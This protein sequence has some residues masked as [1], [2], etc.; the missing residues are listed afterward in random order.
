MSDNSSETIGHFSGCNCP[1]C[2]GGNG[3]IDPVEG[4]YQDGFYGGQDG[5]PSTYGTTEQMVTQL[6]SGY[7]QNVGWDAHQWGTS[8]VTY[9]VSSAYT[10]S[11]KASFAMAFSLWSEVADISFQLVASG[12]QISIVE[13]N[14]GSAWSGNTSY[15][16]STMNM[17]S[18]TISIDTD[19]AGWDDIVTIGKYG[20]QTIL[21]EIGHSLGLG[22][23]GNYNGNVNY[24][25]QVQYLNDNRQYS[26][27]SYNNANLLG[28]DHWAQNGVWQY[29]ATPMLY[30]IIAIQQIYGANTT[31]RAG[32]T[33]YGFNSNAGHSQY[34]LSVSSAPFA[35]WDGG[36]TDTLD[37]SGYSTNQVITLVEGAFT[38]AGYMTNNIAIA[39]GAVI[40][41]A[42]GG[43]GSD[44]ITGNAANNILQGGGGSDTL[45]GSTGSDTLD[46][47][48]GTDTAVYS[49]DLSAF[50][51]FIVDAVTLTLQHIADA[52]ADTVQN[53]ENFNFNGA[54]YT[55]A[56]M[57]AFDASAQPLITTRFDWNGET[58]RYRSDSVGTETITAAT[59]GYDG[60]SGNM[61]SFERDAQELV[62]TI[63]DASA[64]GTMSIGASADDDAITITGTHNS[65]SLNVYGNAGND[66][67][68][69]TSLLG[70][71]SLYGGSGN[72]TISGGGGD[73]TIY[74]DKVKSNDVATGN[75]ILYGNDGNDTIYGHDG[76]DTLY[77]GNDNDRLYGGNDA[78]TLHGGAGLDLLYGDAGN[79]TLN[80]DAGDDILYGGD[81]DDVLN[82]GD[83]VDMLYGDAGDDTLHG[84]AEND[85]LYGD[86]GTDILYGDAGNDRLYGMNGDDTLYGGDGDDILYGDKVK[87]GDAFTGNDTLYGGEGN[88]TLIGHSG[89]DTLYGE[90]GGDK[91][92]GGEDAD[93]LSGGTGSDVLYG[94]DGN[95]LLIGGS[96]K[97]YL[98]GGAGNDTFGF[99]S[100]DGSIDII[101]DFTLNGAEKDNLNITDLLSG[102][103][104]GVNDINDFAQLIYRSADRTDL[105]INGDGA[106]SDWQYVAIIR[107][108]DFSGTGTADLLSSGQLITDQSL[109]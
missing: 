16:P 76:T 12:A 24:D 62:V 84:N 99:A 2:A 34:D 106:G 107:G 23:Q 63:L 35:I 74:G 71:H 9:S 40:E 42:I 91:L 15:N 37:L 60:A 30:D 19:V 33:I 28:T 95:D 29:A 82:G 88:D 77:G 21:H 17:I 11:E 92:Y 81:G 101:Y 8:T 66:T 14:D 48:D 105:R 20:V 93:T 32:N 98:Y 31:T 43:S 64:P 109:A 56:E 80:G 94:E 90:N 53:I 7:W 58:Y 72:D 79:D 73:D 68:T 89:S 49:Y 44:S 102:F 25:T 3:N 47:G 69:V 86:E 41:N 52:W 78:D 67:I 103:V 83:G 65:L 5:A 27:M 85:T 51:V 87:S 36:G 57:S 4:N 1:S 39:F 108:S 6:V 50:L 45:N 61:V 26:I 55:F 54:A 75:D 96:E 22:H 46:G 70:G 18:N 59:M 10:A 13:G 104:Q 100:M 38:S 97:D